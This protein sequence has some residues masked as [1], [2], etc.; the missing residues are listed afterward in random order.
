MQVVGG[1]ELLQD[2]GVEVVHENSGW[3]AVPSPTGRRWREAPDEGMDFPLRRTLAA[4][5]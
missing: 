1:V 3:P 5:G 4:I 2:A